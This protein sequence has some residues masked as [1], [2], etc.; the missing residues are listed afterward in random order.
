MRTRQRLKVYMGLILIFLLGTVAGT[1]GMGFY[2]KEQEAR[3]QR[4]SLE[5]RPAMVMQKLT[6]KLALSLA[7]LP[8]IDAIVVAL[9][10][11]LRTLRQ[12]FS[13]EVRRIFKHDLSLMKEKL[14]PEQQRK[15]DEI[16]ARLMKRWGHPS[17]VN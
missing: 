7:Q 9:E 13:P 15:L 8:E 2:M 12:R 17:S 5:V 16:H 4:G 11:D 1:L 10:K 6:S 3:F 14:R